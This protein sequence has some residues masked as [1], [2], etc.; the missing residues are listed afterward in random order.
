M[1][2]NPLVAAEY[3]GAGDTM[4]VWAQ[5]TSVNGGVPEVNAT[6]VRILPVIV[7]DPGLPT[8]SIDMT[9]Q[10]VLE[11]QQG[12]GLEEILNLDVEVRHNLVSNSRDGDTTLSLGT[13]V[14]TSDSSGGFSEAARWAVGLTPT[15][16]P[17]MS[18]GET[19]QA[20]LT[21]QGPADDYS[22]AGS[23]SIP[24]TATPSL[25]AATAAPT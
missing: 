5:A 25:G 10:Q 21:V 19:R 23:L 17:G 9:V 7:V 1:I 2:Q 13:P 16:L 12:S 15:S 11:A 6:P 3:N 24:I 4:S 20:V 22:V 8:E 14:F 18:L